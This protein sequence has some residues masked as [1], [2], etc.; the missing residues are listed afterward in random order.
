LLSVAY[1]AV[2]TRRAVPKT[3]DLEETPIPQTA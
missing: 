3:I 1:R 2:E